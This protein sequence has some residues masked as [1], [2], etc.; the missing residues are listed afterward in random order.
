MNSTG[1]TIHVITFAMRNRFLIP[2]LLLLMSGPALAQVDPGHDHDHESGSEPG[3]HLRCGTFGWIAANTTRDWKGRDTASRSFFSIACD[4]RHVK[5]HNL[6]T[7]DNHFRIH[8]DASG[9]DAVPSADLNLN[10]IP[11]FVDSVDYYLEYTWDIEIN[12]YGYLPPPPD[13]RGL[14]PEIDVYLCDLNREYYGL[15]RPEEDNPTGPHTV[16]GFLVLENDFIGYP[17]AGIAGLRVTIAHEFHHIVQFSRYYYDF[18]QA[19]LYE[20]TSVWFERKIAPDVRDYLQYVREFLLAPQDVGLSTQ[21]VLGSAAGYAHV[22]FM[23]YLEKKIGAEAIRKIWERFA[24]EEDMFKAL[25]LVLREH[26]MN[27]ENA[28]C[29]F[30]EW[31][32]YTGTRAVE[33]RYFDD[34]RLF[35]TMRPAASRIFDGDDLLIQGFLYPLGFGLYQVIVPSDTS[36]TRDTIDFLITNARTDFGRG[37]PSL[38]KDTF[39]LELTQMNRNGYRPLASGGD[40]LFFKLEAAS[41]KFCVN[42]LFGGKAV[43]FVASYV[44]PQPFINDG[45]AR[46]VFGVNL[47]Q[48]QVQHAKLW[49]YSAALTRVREIEQVELLSFN[50]QL[51]VLWDGRDYLGQLAPSGVYI[52]ELSINDGAPILGKF[53]VIRK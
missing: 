52:Y 34:A 27:L 41:P 28:F 51:G 31:C 17:S 4:Q 35:P 6:V 46:L 32:Y 50:N 7:S 20:A 11:D 21:N 1:S 30:A 18:S 9:R 33:T 39:G 47:A 14:G 38:R 44:S 48:E 40:T 45:G 2:L 13:N 43:S 5:Q 53:A 36:S 26:E 19:S 15:A 8:W 29:E 24:S 16:N 49:I 23:E 22:L 42:P 10:G 3:D 25:D 12:E 37:G